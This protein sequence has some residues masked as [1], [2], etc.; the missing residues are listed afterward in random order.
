MDNLIK[1]D[2]LSFRRITKNDFAVLKE[3]LSDIDVMY[4]WEHA[5][6]DDEIYAWINKRISHYNKFGYDYFI[7]VSN[8]TGKVIGQIGLVHETVN[9]EHCIALGYILNKKFWHNGFATEAA[10]AM[11]Q[12]AFSVIKAPKVIA[13]IRPENIASINVANRL[14]MLKT[15]EF[16]K[17][18][19]GKA[20]VHYVFEINIT[21]YKEKL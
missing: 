7:A 14:G 9:D 13:T 16:I 6:S 17:H 10:N 1:T 2:R 18:Y 12:Y 4:A 19:N 5:F 20:M 15:G 8:L 21:T 11:L 3:M